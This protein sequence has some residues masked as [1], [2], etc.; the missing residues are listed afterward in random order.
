MDY[1]PI[2]SIEGKER[3][4]KSR[5][6]AHGQMSANTSRDLTEFLSLPVAPSTFFPADNERATSSTDAKS[7]NSSESPRTVRSTHTGA[8]I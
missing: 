1:L 8:Q 3:Q 4:E 2:H 5:N 6:S 7:N